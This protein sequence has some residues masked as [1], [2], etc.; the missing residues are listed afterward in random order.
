MLLKNWRGCVMVFDNLD[1]LFD[2]I[3]DDV[4]DVLEH[5]V[6]DVVKEHMKLAVNSRVYD[7]YT[8]EYYKRRMSNGGLSDI[9]NM[10]AK[11]EG[12]TLTVRDDAPLDNGR[13]DYALDEIIV[14]GYGNQPFPRDFY[15]ETTEWLIN[16]G[17]HVGALKAGLK[18][19]GY[20]V[21]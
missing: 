15:A 10:E 16:T 19:M 12:N 18:G 2:Q 17:D 7:A 14:N 4:Q 5:E 1:S 9:D 6:A 3:E 11:V 13:T 20:K 8:P 21:K